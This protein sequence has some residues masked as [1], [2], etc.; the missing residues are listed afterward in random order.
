VYKSIIKAKPNV[1]YS[2]TLEI[3]GAISSM[4]IPKNG[5]HLRVQLVGDLPFSYRKEISIKND[6]GCLDHVSGFC[7]GNE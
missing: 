1:Y 4:N 6:I 5:V 7:P 2:S 3:Y